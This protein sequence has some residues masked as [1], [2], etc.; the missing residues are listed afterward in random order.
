MCKNMN[1]WYAQP[2][3]LMCV[4]KSI[5]NLK[6]WLWHAKPMWEDKH[7][8]TMQAENKE[9][10]LDDSHYCCWYLHSSPMRCIICKV[11]YL[12]F[13]LAFPSPYATF[14]HPM[15]QFKQWKSHIFNSLFWCGCPTAGQTNVPAT[16]V[17]AT[18]SSCSSC[19]SY[20]IMDPS[21]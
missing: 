4:L 9:S 10:F 2:P 5:H 11:N 6:A 19:W 18:P 16:L 13:Q 14:V 8:K 1:K 12:Y 15:P 17:T 3:K 7:G 20:W 21:Y